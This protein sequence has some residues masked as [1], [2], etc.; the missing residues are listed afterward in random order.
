MIGQFDDLTRNDDRCLGESVGR[1]QFG[2]CDIDALGD[3]DERVIGLD[4]VEQSLRN[5]NRGNPRSRE[6]HGA[7]STHDAESGGRTERD[8]SGA[9][10]KLDG[11]L[12]E[13]L[14]RQSRRRS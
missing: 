13:E 2:E 1:Q 4:R 5:R 14:F 8:E 7:G 10:K 6:R 11:L 9:S 12:H 3:T